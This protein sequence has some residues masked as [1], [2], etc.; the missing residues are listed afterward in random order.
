VSWNKA[1]D[2]IGAVSAGMI[3]YLLPLFSGLAA[4]I[5]L[6]EKLKYYHF[7]S[8]VLIISGILISNRKS[9]KLKN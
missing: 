4:W 3:Y 5:V 1:I 6:S 9:R 7:I 2:K 8:A